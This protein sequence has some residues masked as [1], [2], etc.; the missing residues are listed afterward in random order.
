MYLLKTAALIIGIAVFYFVAVYFAVAALAPGL[1]WQAAL[2]AVIGA[3]LL[4][5]FLGLTGSDE[6]GL[7][8]GLL[9]LA[10]IICV[11]AGSIWWL[12]RLLGLFRTN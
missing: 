8:L 1:A 2:L 6:A 4:Y 12:L 5:R 10:P 3:M 7:P 9:L 11:A